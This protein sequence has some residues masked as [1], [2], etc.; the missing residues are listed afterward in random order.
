MT[1]QD[2]KGKRVV[3]MGLGLYGGGR[4]AAQWSFEQGAATIV[5]DVKDE[6]ALRDSV[7]A[8]NKSARAYRLAHPEQ[9]LI[10]ITYA[11]GGHR[12][13][14]FA[15]A[16]LIIQNPGVPRESPFLGIAR[17][18]GIP[19]HNEVTLFYLL[20]PHT[21]KIAVTG[22]RGKSTT[23]AL[24][25]HIL[26]S[27]YNDTVLVGVAGTPDSYSFLNIITSAREHEQRGSPLTVVMELSSW[28]LELFE[29]YH[30]HPWISVITNVLDDHLNRYPSFEAYR[31]T[32]KLIYQYQEKSE[33]TVL[34][35][36]NEY[37]RA[38][39]QAG[40]PGTLVW[41]TRAKKLTGGGC[42]IDGSSLHCTEGEKNEFLCDL[43]DTYKDR[44]HM[45]ENILAA[46]AGAL[47]AGVTQKILCKTIDSFSGLPGRLELVR[48]ISGRAAYDDTTAT[49]PDATRAALRSLG[50]NGDPRIILIAGGADKN[51]DYALLGADI[52]R[53]CRALILLSGTA[54]P[55]IATS[56]GP[57]SNTIAFANSMKEAVEK[58]WSISREGDILLLSPA[59]ASF[60]MFVNEFDRG[61]HYREA[62]EELS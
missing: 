46:S 2:L 12:E 50:G 40:V 11:L 33:Y 60:G 52:A 37:T 24:L 49:S 14:D 29:E 16:D 3:V 25:Y 38:F 43:A 62:L 35:H 39:G 55:R 20:T 36:D 48:E 13:Q 54:S 9:E 58:A 10:S 5:T 53:Y 56:L 27:H 18:N 8:L 51:C 4:A 7:V 34:N 21:P 32:K 15:S 1:P 28:Q 47:C 59:A 19:I 41:F 61:R 26:K 42:F 45:V 31:D 22:T 30:C 44:P 17:D 23:S 6:T 57:F